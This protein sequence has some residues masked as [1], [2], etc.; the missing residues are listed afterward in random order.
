MNGAEFPLTMAAI[1]EHDAAVDDFFVA[2]LA[3]KITQDCLSHPQFPEDKMCFINDLSISKASE[4][5]Y[6]TWRREKGIHGTGLLLTRVPSII[7]SW[8]KT[9]ALDDAARKPV[10]AADDPRWEYIDTPKAVP[11]GPGGPPRDEW[12]RLGRPNY[13]QWMAYQ[14][15]KEVL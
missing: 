4:H 12:V 2:S 6:R 7:I 3:S 5:S 13:E 9:S 14:A 11:D 8:A 15:L 10:A 1:R